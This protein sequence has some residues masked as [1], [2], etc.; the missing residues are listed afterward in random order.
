MLQGHM[1]PMD[2]PQAALDM[3]TRFTRNKPLGEP[4]QPVDAHQPSQQ[5]SAGRTRQATKEKQVKS[6]MNVMAR[7]GGPQQVQSS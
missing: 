2:Q 6:Q 1:V 7:K 4:Q 5:P 3:I